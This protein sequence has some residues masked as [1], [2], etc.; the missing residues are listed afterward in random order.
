MLNDTRRLATAATIHDIRP[1]P[2]ADAIEYG[3]V[4]GWPVVIGKGEF[5]DGEAVLYIEPDAALP[6]DDPRFA[7]L[8]SRGTKTIDDKVYHVL[9]TIRLRGQLSQGIVFPAT[10]FPEVNDPDCDLDAALGILLWEPPQAPVGADWKGPWNLG[11]LQKTDA[12]RVQNLS[13]DWLATADDG[14]WVATEKIDGSSI[15]Y[16]LGEDGDLH[17]YSRNNELEP[18]PTSTPMELAATYEVA[19]WMRDHKV[20]AIQAEMYGNQI[21]SNRLRVSGHRLAVFAAWEHRLVAG[22]LAH[23]RLDTV[24]NSPGT[25]PAVPVFDLP[26]PHTIEEAIA[27][28]DGLKSLVNPDRL[29]EGIVWHHIGDADFPDLDYRLVFKAVSPAYLIKYGL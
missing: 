9:R 12:E 16:A 23:D 11:W 26:F 20:D 13:D 7:N 27:Q 17:I 28:A 25:L 14:L 2:D 15:T 5:H 1:I 10:A 18:D 29:A 22:R 8:A 6:V 19:D 24:L 4:R 3:L 21:Q